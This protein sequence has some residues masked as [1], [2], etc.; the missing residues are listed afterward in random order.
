MEHASSNSHKEEDP[1]PD[2]AARFRVCTIATKRE[3]PSTILLAQS[4]AAHH[5][6]IPIAV[7]IV[8]ATAGDFLSG[9]PFNVL[10]SEAIP[11]GRDTLRR[12]ATYYDAKELSAAL[13]PFLLQHLL[14][15]GDDAVMYLDHDIEVFAPLDDLFT[16]ARDRIV[17]TPHITQ[18]MCRD[19]LGVPDEETFLLHGQFNLGF[20]AVSD[21]SR[22]FL[23][24]WSQRTRLFALDDPGKGYFLDQRWVDAA[25]GMF[26]CSIIRDQTCNVGYWNLHERDLG[27]DASGTW[28][29]GSRPLRFFSFSGHNPN[30]P[31][32]LSEN[33]NGIL[34]VRVDQQPALRR[35][36]HER[37]ERVLAVRGTADPQ[38]YGWSRTTGGMQLTRPIRRLY[39][40]AVRHAEEEAVA[41]PPHAFEDDQGRGFLSWLREPVSPGNPV[42]RH[43]YA[44]WE[45]QPDLQAAFP[46]ALGAD[47]RRLTKWARED[48][49][50]IHTTPVQLRAEPSGPTT[51]LSGVNLLGYLDGEFGV[52]AAGRMLSR[53]ISASGVP[54][55]TTLL[56]T[57]AHR[58]RY[59]YLATIEGAPFD[60]TIFAVNAAELLHLSQTAQITHY[61]RR[62]RVGV[63]YWEVGVFPDFMR[64][65]FDLVDEVWCAS[66]HVHAALTACGATTVRKHPLV[67]ESPSTPTALLRTDLGLPS[68]RFLYGFVFDYESVLQRK[69]PIGLIDAYR[70]AFGPE[71]DTAL[72]LKAINGAR[73]PDAAAAVR[74]AAD[75][76]PD[77]VFL[78]QHLDAVQMRGLF[79]LL[80]CYVSLHRSEGLGLTIAT[81]MAAGTPAIAT[82]WSGN[83]EFMNAQNSV[84]VPYDLTEVGPG[85]YPYPPDACWAE[86][87]LDAAAHAMRE[88]Y[89]HP[90]MAPELGR[91]GASTVTA[92]HG[93]RAAADW[94][95]E[96]FAT[97]SQRGAEV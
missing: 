81:A 91:R 6:K 40:D 35:V 53:M 64:P 11:V 87:D 48:A 86:P 73:R 85:A 61:P 12:M 33:L 19:T 47:A 3:L 22:S 20:L 2:D 51:P 34:R 95:D 62:N 84:L 76:R 7:L 49:A 57:D 44:R 70:R 41:P 89:D 21:A 28:T 93:V 38:P 72:V 96:Q 32:R 10:D 60:V 17:L 4:F 16:I 66:D 65:A 88:F 18:P 30:E 68:D 13:K 77:I 59:P 69:N 36:L 90:A 24:Y 37:A 67:I 58:H 97:L 9:L 78:D 79:G 45:H 55:A 5:A 52:A 25:P 94:F 80:D 42:P 75:E 74:E 14:D 63:W 43:V 1:S 23:D 82:G 46:D 83:L 92:N 54:V 56:R 29:V 31:F 27:F 71:D 39:W 50:A 26:D 8:D 15:S